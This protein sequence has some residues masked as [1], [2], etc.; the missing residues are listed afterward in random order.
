MENTKKAYKIDRRKFIQWVYD[1]YPLR[2]IR[3]LDIKNNLIESGEYILTAEDMLAEFIEVP[4]YLVV[5]IDKSNI[6]GVV[7]VNASGC[8]LIFVP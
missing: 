1:T 3:I 4:A 8:E 7:S 2:L 6:R 5:G